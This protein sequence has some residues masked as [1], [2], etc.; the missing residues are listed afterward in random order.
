VMFAGVVACPHPEHDFDGK[1]YLRQASET[2]QAKKAIYY[3]NVVDFHEVNDLIHRTWR[4]LHLQALIPSM[5]VGELLDSS[6]AIYEFGIDEDTRETLVLRYWTYSSSSKT[7]QKKKW[8]TL[9]EDD[10]LLAHWI[11]HE[12]TSALEP[13][14]LED[15]HLLLLEGVF[16]E[17]VTSL[18]CPPHAT[19]SG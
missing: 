4:T 8:V 18:R 17:V 19:L 12:S 15:I 14:T 5:M 11:R 10:L 9:D 13:I 2:V 1:I 3:K 6:L 16:A 7:T